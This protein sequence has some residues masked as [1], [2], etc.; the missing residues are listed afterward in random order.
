MK[1]KIAIPGAADPAMMAAL[2]AHITGR[3]ARVIYDKDADMHAT[4]KRHP[5]LVRWDAGFEPDGRLRNPI[6]RPWRHPG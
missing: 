6:N 5:Y 4:G 2:V 1:G 3:P